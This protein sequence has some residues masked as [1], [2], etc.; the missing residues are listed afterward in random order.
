MILVDRSP[1]SG[2]AIK[3]KVANSIQGVS[4]LQLAKQFGITQKAAWFMIHRIKEACGNDNN[5]M[6]S[7]IVEIDEIFIGGLSWRP[8]AAAMRTSARIPR[9]ILT[10]AQ[11]LTISSNQAAAGIS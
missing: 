8:S 2:F 3:L 11:D 10:K 5:T 4:S 7:R 6:L 1:V 9:V